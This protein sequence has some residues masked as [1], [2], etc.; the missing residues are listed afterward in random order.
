MGFA[1]GLA[2][3]GRAGHVDA[4]PGPPRRREARVRR[5]SVSSELRIT[6]VAAGCSVASER[7]RAAAESA[8][9]PP[10]Q[11]TRV[12]R[13]ASTRLKS[14][15]LPESQPLVL[16]HHGCAGRRSGARGAERS[17]RGSHGPGLLGERR[18]APDTPVAHRGR[19]W[20]RWR[21]QPQSRGRRPAPKKSRWRH[22]PRLSAR[23]TP[24]LA[25]PP[26]RG[27][28]RRGG[29]ARNRARRGGRAGGPS[30]MLWARATPCRAN[31]PR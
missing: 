21:A 29:L 20:Q 22:R 12:R 16:G 3:C 7:T 14:D 17:R 18:V 2:V 19:P 8:S 23:P 28:A 15:R 27:P 1:S 11:P 26:C 31:P 24:A 9:R 5:R 25:Q 13:G 6:V 30:A 4:S 10:R